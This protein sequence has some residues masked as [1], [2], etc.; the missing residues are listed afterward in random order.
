MRT[1]NSQPG[2]NRPM[3]SMTCHA[4]PP[5]PMPH[6]PC[7]VQKR[8]RGVGGFAMVRWCDASDVT[9]SGHPLSVSMQSWR[10]AW[11]GLDSAIRGIRRACVLVRFCYWFCH[12]AA[13]T[14]LCAA[15]VGRGGG[16][17]VT[18]VSIVNGSSIHGVG[19]LFFF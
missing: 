6:A 12:C 8:T 18:S 7:H 1:K 3:D 17:I 15:F 19:A 14:F 5:T 11:R 9:F 13:F 16:N 10:L 2:R 4:T